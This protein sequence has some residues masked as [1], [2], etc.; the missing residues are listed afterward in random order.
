MPDLGPSF[1]K[2]ARGLKDRAER[3]QSAGP[4]AES[5]R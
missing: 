5:G 4:A 3:P 1:E 2:F